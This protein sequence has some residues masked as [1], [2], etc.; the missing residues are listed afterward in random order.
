MENKLY[1]QMYLKT[2]ILWEHA[3]TQKPTLRGKLRN[4]HKHKK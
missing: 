3:Q 1:F 2:Q 4:T